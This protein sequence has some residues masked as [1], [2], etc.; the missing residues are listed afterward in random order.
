MASERG[1]DKETVRAINE[2][3]LDREVTTPRTKKRSKDG[4]KDTVIDLMSY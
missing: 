1:I 4:K 2:W 3:N